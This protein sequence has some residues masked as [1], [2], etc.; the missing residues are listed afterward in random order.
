MC[1][2]VCVC[3]RVSVWI[4]TTC[5][6]FRGYEFFVEQIFGAALL[7]I[8]QGFLQQTLL[9][10]KSFCSG[11]YYWATVFFATSFTIGQEFLQQSLE[12]LAKDDFCNRLYC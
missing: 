7:V 2:R 6:F 8:N 4:R 5:V 12:L 10:A 1:V 3:V 11:L 9:L